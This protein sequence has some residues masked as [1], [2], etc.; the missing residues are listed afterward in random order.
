[1]KER[2]IVFSGEM[3]RAILDGRK[4]QTRRVI[5]NPGFDISS[6][7][8]GCFDFRDRRQ[9]WNTLTEQSF[10]E[11]CPYGKP[12]DRLWVREGWWDEG[13]WKST[14]HPEPD[15]QEHFWSS[16]FGRIAYCASTGEQDLL[17]PEPGKTWRKR[18]SIHLPRRFARILLEITAARVERLQEINEED[19]KAEGAFF[20]DYGRQCFHKGAPRDAVKCPAPDDHHPRRDGWSMLPTESH[21]QCLSSARMAFASLWNSINGKPHIER[22]DDGNEIAQHDLSW[23]ANPWVWVVEFRVIEPSEVAA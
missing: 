16:T 22:D 17:A 8:E 15:C 2:P 6:A 7:A 4:T 9:R 18:P 5:K 11:T 19:A 10:I 1:M 13:E 23:A 20:T 3:V 14:E 21:E 12:G